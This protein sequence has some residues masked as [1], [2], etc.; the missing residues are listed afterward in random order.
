MISRVEERI[1]VAAIFGQKPWL[2][3][4]WFIWQGRQYR[5]KKITY[6]WVDKEGQEKLY[7]FAVTDGANLYELCYNSIQLTWQLSAIDT[8]G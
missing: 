7:H 4:V 8:E 6:T 3:P 5:V 1:I 2:K